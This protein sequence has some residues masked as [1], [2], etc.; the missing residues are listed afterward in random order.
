MKIINYIFL[1]I[2][3]SSF[4]AAVSWQGLTRSIADTLFINDDGDTMTGDLNIG[5]GGYSS[6]GITLTTDGGA[7]VQDLIL[8]GNITNIGGIE[9]NG[10]LNPAAGVTASL[11]N[12]SNQWASLNVSGNAYA[13][14]LTIIGNIS[15]SYI[16]GKTITPDVHDDLVNK[17]YVDDAVSSTAFDFFFNDD[18]SNIGSHFNMTE[19]DLGGAESTV[20]SASLSAEETL[21]IFNWTTLIDHPEFN[22]VRQGVYDVHF[23]ASK[24][25][26]RPITLT[27]KLY[28]ISS[29]GLTRVL[30]VTFE[31]SSALTTSIEEFDLHGVLSNNVMLNDGDRLNLD[32]EATVGGGSPTTVSIV[33]E[34][35]TDSHMSIETSTNAFEKIFVRRDGT[36][37]LTGNWDVG[38]FDIVNIGN[39]G[40]G[41]TSPAQTLTVQGRVNISQNLTVNNSVLF[42]DGTAGRVGIGTISPGYILNINKGGGGR[43]AVLGIDYDVL[44][45]IST[46]RGG[47]IL[48]TPSEPN[49]AGALINTNYWNSVS[50]SRLT[51]Q[52][53]NNANQLVLHEG[54]NV[55]IGTTN[56]AHKLTVEGNLNV[57]TTLNVSGNISFSQLISCDTINTDATG[58][59]T[60]G[61]DATGSGEDPLQFWNLANNDTLAMINQLSLNITRGD[62][63]ALGNTSWAITAVNDSIK[64]YYNHSI[65][66]S[67]YITN[68]VSDLVNYFTQTEIFDFFQ[69]NIT[70]AN[71]SMKSYVDNTFVVNTGDDLTGDYNH[72]S[73]EVLM[74]P[75]NKTCYGWSCEGQIYYNDSSLVIK[76]T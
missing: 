64:D 39:V 44:N 4:A 16:L 67:T 74:A 15:T 65:D 37:Q 40:I 43:G 13:D 56:P 46:L 70:S 68:A 61:T 76:V 22:Q 27:P 55:G 34:G 24:S 17:N 32:I 18:T 19:P 58:L 73:G 25:G 60:C 41:T 75:F 38:G 28:N 14:S 51:L 6:G 7:Y 36:N 20:T 57:S 53:Y 52:S 71:A 10:S 3:L 62:I 26:S 48:F 42:V 66:L 47:T 5:V 9:V 72:T 59:L 31:T 49:G 30:L 23:H 69:T 29:D 45:P 21:S 35:T 1:F 33:L 54:G 8:A 2:V 12:G 11:G 50:E 63:I